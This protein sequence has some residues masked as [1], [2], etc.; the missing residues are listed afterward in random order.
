MKPS[1]EVTS[2]QE[3]LDKIMNA[4]FEPID[5]EYFINWFSETHGIGRW[6]VL[7]QIKHYQNNRII[8]IKT[9][10]IDGEEKQVIMLKDLSDI[11]RRAKVIV[12]VL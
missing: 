9:G 2:W 11:E 12:K 3:H 5:F 7:N 10:F 6:M 1:Y 8:E 4:F